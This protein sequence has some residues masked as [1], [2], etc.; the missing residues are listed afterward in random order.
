MN[1]GLLRTSYGEKWVVVRCSSLQSGQACWDLERHIWAL[2]PPRCWRIPKANGSR[3]PPT[4]AASMER[5]AAV[6]GPAS[7][8][9][10]MPH[11]RGSYTRLG[12]PQRNS[13]IPLQALLETGGPTAVAGDAHPEEPARPA[14]LAP[15]SRHRVMAM[16][17]P[18][19][20][21]PSH[22]ADGRA[23]PSSP[24]KASPQPQPRRRGAGGRGTRPGRQT[25]WPRG[26]PSSSALSHCS[27]SIGDPKGSGGGHLPGH[28]ATCSQRRGQ[29][30]R[31]AGQTAPSALVKG[32]AASLE[33]EMSQ[34]R[35]AKTSG[36]EGPA[37]GAGVAAPGTRGSP[38]ISLW[39]LQRGP[40]AEEASDTG[41]TSQLSRGRRR[42]VHGV[43]AV[44]GMLG[45]LG[46]SGTSPSH[47]GRPRSDTVLPNSL[48]DTNSYALADDLDR[49]PATGVAAGR[50][51]ESPSA[52]TSQ[53]KPR[54]CEQFIRVMPTR[55]LHCKEGSELANGHKDSFPGLTS[56]SATA[57]GGPMHKL[58]LVA[59]T[60]LSH[61]TP[62]L[63][64][65][66]SDC[67]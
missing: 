35:T 32:L 31:A 57:A 7:P 62:S 18:E 46:P 39:R 65:D 41:W 52:R 64:G 47:Q 21:G 48:L 37:V 67:G 55:C 20:T 3:R 49:S 26:G 50:S 4:P 16:K 15:D 36:Q 38:C 19:G 58:V 40:A 29:V 27:S 54:A 53:N 33:P 51:G 1:P 42:P 2:G 17:R 34:T 9:V 14:A 25:A 30:A 22:G 63:C 66:T 8:G 43:A 45:T 11:R 5:G 28:L 61:W 10:G 12:L 60:Q 56:H 23:T 44:T 24:Y 13:S 59:C 6:E